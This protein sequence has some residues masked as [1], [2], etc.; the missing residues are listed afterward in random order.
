[1]PLLNS[2]NQNS[3]RR[4]LLAA[5]G[6]WRWSW[7]NSKK[8]LE[9]IESRDETSS[10]NHSEEDEDKKGVVTAPTNPKR[11]VR[12]RESTSLIPVTLDDSEDVPRWYQDHDYMR[13]QKDRVLTS[14]D[15][16]SSSTKSNFNNETEHSIRGLE[17]FVNKKMPRRLS[18][19]KKDLLSALK[20]EEASQK[21]DGDFPNLERFRSV[22]LKYTKSA[23]DRALVLGAEDAKVIHHG[24]QKFWRNS[25]R[26]FGLSS[27]PDRTQR[28]L[29]DE[30]AVYSC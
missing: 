18:L 3:N 13:F 19:E 26:K 5:A 11:S 9:E 10:T 23:R 17:I 29:E 1:M 7:R 28:R 24:K 21:E 16:N 20:A 22:S 12:F 14:L 4:Q 6:L 27:T 2:P 15:Y 8:K 30:R 25:R